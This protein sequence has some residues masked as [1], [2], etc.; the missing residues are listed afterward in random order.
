MVSD[1]YIVS[2]LRTACDD[3]KGI[4]IAEDAIR[5]SQDRMIQIDGLVAV[6]VVLIKL[7]NALSLLIGRPDTPF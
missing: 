5:S 6:L 7:G 3:R 1:G 4:D 2:H